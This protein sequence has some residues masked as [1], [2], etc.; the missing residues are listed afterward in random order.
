MAILLHFIIHC[1]VWFAEQITDVGD[2]SEAWNQN[3]LTLKHFNSSHSSSWESNTYTPAALSNERNMLIPITSPRSDAGGMYSTSLILV[4]PC[5]QDINE[6]TGPQSKLTELNADVK[7]SFHNLRLRIQVRNTTSL[8]RW[9]MF[10]VLIWCNVTA[11]LV[12]ELP[13][14]SVNTEQEN[15][16]F[17][18]KWWK[19]MLSYKIKLNKMYSGAS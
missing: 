1:S 2:N 5:H 14:T 15:M 11:T 7:K 9:H 8:Y 17:L 3:R 19:A 12:Y 4:S 18:S 16:V 10:W 6:C 13:M